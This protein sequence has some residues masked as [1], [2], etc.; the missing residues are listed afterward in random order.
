MGIRKEKHVTNRGFTLI[1]LLIVITVIG[2]LS[3]IILVGLGGVRTRGRDTRRI[4]DLRQVQNALEL[5]FDRQR[6]YPN[7]TTW[8]GLETELRNQGIL[9]SAGGLAQ[10]PINNTTYFYDYR[11]GSGGLNYVLRARLE[12]TD[13]Q[14]LRDD[15]D[16]ANIFGLDC[17]T[18]APPS[19]P[20]EDPAYYCIQL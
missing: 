3:S 13:N 1:E 20:Y 12:N 7:V 8:T 14:A 15:V 2:L 6:T 11:S 9:T 5:Y 19:P 18:D 17:G 10:D 16:G 4:A